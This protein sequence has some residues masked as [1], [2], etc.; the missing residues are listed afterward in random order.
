MMPLLLALPIYV[1]YE[2]AINIYYFVITFE[3][4][5]SSTGVSVSK[6]G[7]TPIG[8]GNKD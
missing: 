3:G 6:T 1:L 2:A 8:V 4:Y 7:A 5:D